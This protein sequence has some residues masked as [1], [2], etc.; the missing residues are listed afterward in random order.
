M[1]LGNEVFF[2]LQVLRLLPFHCYQIHVSQPSSYN[3]TTF[4]SVTKCTQSFGLEG[5]SDKKDKSTAVKLAEM[6]Y[7]NDVCKMAE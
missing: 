3:F 7:R 2:C 4:Q 5:S 1:S 6:G